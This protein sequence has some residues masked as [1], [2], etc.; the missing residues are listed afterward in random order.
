M[1]QLKQNV[2]SQLAFLCT[3][4]EAPMA[5]FKVVI[6]SDWTVKDDPGTGWGELVG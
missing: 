2:E 1:Q 6:C 3:S 4:V 5:S